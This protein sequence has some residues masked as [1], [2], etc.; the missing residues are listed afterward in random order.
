[1][2]IV[3]L[4]MLLL[5]AVPIM[6]QRW[7][8]T[9]EKA[10]AAGLSGEVLIAENGKVVYHKARGYRSFE[11]KKKVRKGDIFEFASVSKQ[12]TAMVILKLVQAGKLGLDDSL[13]TYVA[14]PYRGITLRHL[15]TH[16]SGLP[17][18]QAIMDRHWDK[19][20]VAGNPDI[21]AYL[22]RYAP[23][24]LF[25]PG[26]QYTYSN[27][28][29]VLL[30]SVA[31]IASGQDF[32]AL[33]NQLIFEPLGMQ[34]TRIRTP[35]Q[36]DG[37]KKLAEG[38]IKDSTGSYLHAKR[39]RAADYTL[40]L[41]NRKGP[42]RVSGTAADLLRWDRAL[43]SPDFL[44]SVLLRE[45]FN[46]VVLN[47]GST[48]PYGFG[49][50]IVA[51]GA[52]KIVKHNGDNPGYKTQIIRLLSVDKVAILLCNNYHPAFEGLVKAIEGMFLSIE[53]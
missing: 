13:H 29:Y 24:R 36:K 18:Y 26:Q 8:D 38:H 50:D 37:L 2:R 14:T 5:A 1:M 11:S 40:W 39:F 41:G 4:W 6:A 20:K 19:S 3:I 48:F 51:Q 28:G 27:T 17:D 31:E 53:K 10:F 43:R 15:L 47:D 45:A 49:W 12:F 44:D 22:N 32:I 34:H 9:V 35:Q 23:P 21:I 30:A 52:Q 25:D 7:Q 42:G 16:T 46:P 33:S